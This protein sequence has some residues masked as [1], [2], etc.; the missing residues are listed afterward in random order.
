MATSIPPHNAHELCD[1]ALHLIK[2]PA[3]TIEE[4]MLD[5][6]N[7][8][9][10]GIEGPDLPTGGVIID[11]RESIIEAYKTGRGGFRVRAK[12]EVEDTGRGGYQIIVTEIPF[13]VQ[14]SRL[15]EKIA[16]LLL[17]RK[18]PLLE[19]V[20]DRSAEDV[21]LVLVPKSRSRLIRRS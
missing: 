14:K 12:W 20:R 11:S 4:L 10:G 5:P 18:L 6:N 9:R 1:A 7:P 2:N 16:E 21:R 19:D 3:A 13:Q 15:I 17:A 8:E